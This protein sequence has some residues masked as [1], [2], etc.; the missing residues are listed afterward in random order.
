VSTALLITMGLVASR[1]GGVMMLMPAFGARGV[2]M[3]AKIL[4]VI[5]LT[6][7]I[8]PT[9]PLARVTPSIGYLVLGIGT[10]VIVGVLIGGVVAFVFGAVSLANE[11]MSNQ[12]GH[13]AAQLFDPML[14]VSHGPLA[15]LGSLLATL[16]FL[17]TN[18]HLTLLVNVADSFHAVPP[19]M[20]S[21]PF[22][23]G[24]VWVEVGQ[25]VMVAGISLAGPVLV[26]IFLIHCFVAVITRLAPNMNIFFSLGMVM[27]VIAGCWFAMIML[28][29]QLEAH[30]GMVSGAV[31]RVPE[32]FKYMDLVQ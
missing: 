1:M 15:T 18:L 30:Y 7:V 2:P 6:I 4:C 29:Y 13:G 23:A 25:Q 27:T 8:A 21:S 5:G 19:G 10:E 28:P 31:E 32:V 20:V 11:V 14:K 12:V 22:G 16:V 26:L 24:I 17:G 3:T 9:V